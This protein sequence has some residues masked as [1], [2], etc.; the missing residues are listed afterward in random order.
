MEKRGAQSLL[1]VFLILGLLVGE[2]AGAFDT[3]Y[4]VCLVPCMIIEKSIR[5]CGKLCFEGCIRK[6][7]SMDLQKQNHYFCK[8]GCAATLCTNISTKEDPAAEKV[9]GCVNTCS[10]TC[11]KN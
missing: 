7:S 8:L 6:P 3:C 4:G 2:S 10:E 11:T 1:I 5:K 9:E